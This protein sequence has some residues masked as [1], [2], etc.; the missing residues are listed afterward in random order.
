MGMKWLD[1]GVNAVELNV[2]TMKVDRTSNSL[3]N[4]S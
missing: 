2:I 1:L 3:P 4:S